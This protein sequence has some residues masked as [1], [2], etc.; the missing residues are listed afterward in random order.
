MSKAPP[1]SST[2]I[3]P[4]IGQQC[5]FYWPIRRPV[6][7]D[8]E[9]RSFCEGRA[10]SRSEN[11]RLIEYAPCRHGDSRHLQ[12][13]PMNVSAYA[14][15]LQHRDAALDLLAFLTGEHCKYHDL[16]ELDVFDFFHVTTM[17]VSVPIFN[18]VK[19]D[20]ESLSPVLAS[21]WKIAL[22]FQLVARAMTRE[23]LSGEQNTPRTIEPEQVYDFANTKGYLFTKREACA[24]PPRMIVE[25]AEAILGRRKFTGARMETAK[26]EFCRAAGSY[27]ILGS[28]A[29]HV[30]NHFIYDATF[31][32]VGNFI[33][34]D[35]RSLGRKAKLPLQRR[36]R[37]VTL[38]DWFSAAT[39]GN[40]QQ[41]QDWKE[42][43][44]L[45]SRERTTSE[46]IVESVDWFERSQNRC[47]S[48]LESHLRFA[49]DAEPLQAD[50]LASLRFVDLTGVKVSRISAARPDGT[51]CHEAVAS[52][53][54]ALQIENFLC[55]QLDSFARESSSRLDW[56]TARNTAEL[57]G[58]YVNLIEAMAS[59]GSEM[60]AYWAKELCADLY[61]AVSRLVSLVPMTHHRPL[62]ELRDR[63]CHLS[64]GF[65]DYEFDTRPVDAGGWHWLP[66]LDPFINRKNA[67]ALFVFPGKGRVLAWFLAFVLIHP[68][69]KL[70]I[71]EDA[72]R[73]TLLRNLERLSPKINVSLVGGLDKI[74]TPSE[75][76][77]IVVDSVTAVGRLGQL[78]Q[79]EWKLLKP[80][81]LMIF[82]GLD[83]S[84]PPKFSQQ[85]LDT[86]RSIF[87]R[88][89]FFAWKLPGEHP[90]RTKY[91]WSTLSGPV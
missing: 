75:F 40:D 22:G 11:R 24:A 37:R 58:K 35:A 89:V 14:A 76:D 54:G 45:A 69:N 25:A 50:V 80:G 30:V 74:E 65:N 39:I 36:E 17:F 87:M 52:I 1:L 43:S 6:V 2:P 10:D 86:E 77:L 16:R 56:N 72:H 48:S 21:A 18:F 13:L 15:M 29:Q 38:I 71:V 4:S 91:S 60:L 3:L 53:K 42:I 61:R 27:E 31:T 67:R 85:D 23:C 5:L 20:A 46:S 68:S 62:I 34:D 32:L 28:A 73:E 8:S 55:E 64:G 81:G 66:I 78:G 26:S 41:Q 12:E 7:H 57:L 51:A 59:P 44:D 47:I 49:L 84:E 33:A 9:G 83:H 90:I 79:T 19:G 82:L 70:E 63:V 88:N